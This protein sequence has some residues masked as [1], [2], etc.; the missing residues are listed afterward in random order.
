MLSNFQTI[1]QHK[2]N[3]EKSVIL[4]QGTAHTSPLHVNSQNNGDIEWYEKGWGIM[5]APAI[6]AQSFSLDYQSTLKY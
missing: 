6:S 4:C 2:R 1:K 5:C 3:G